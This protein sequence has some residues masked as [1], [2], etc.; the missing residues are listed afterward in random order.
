MALYGSELR[1]YLANGMPKLMSPKKKEELADSEIVPDL[2]MWQCIANGTIKI[3]D[4]SFAGI[5]HKPKEWR[6]R[7]EMRGYNMP[8][9]GSKEPS[10]AVQRKAIK[11]AHKKKWGQAAL[12]HDSAFWTD[13]AAGAPMAS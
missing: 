6:Q 11:D 1:P 8:K 10:M 4:Q 5:I 7:M 2:W 9:V 12:K 13:A 3:G